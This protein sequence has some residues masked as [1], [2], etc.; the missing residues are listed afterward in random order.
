MAALI[1]K[2]TTG[3]NGLMEHRDQRTTNWFLLGSPWPNLLLVAT[4]IFISTKGGPWFM[5]NR[6]PYDIRKIMVA[7]NL[8]MV[9]LSSYMVYE[10]LF[11][12]WLDGYTL[13]C[14]LVDYSDAPQAVRMANVSWWFYFSK[15]IELLDTIFFILRKKFNLVTFLHV[16]H[17]A[18]MPCVE[19]AG[20]SFAPGGFGTFHA[21]LNCSVHVIM[22]TYYG[23][24]AMGP[25]MQKYLWWKR[26]MTTIQIVQLCGM[27]IHS[28]QI[29]F[30][31][32]QYSKVFGYTILIG[33]FSFVPL[34][35]NFYIQAYLSK[36]K[37]EK[38]ERLHQNGSVE[39]NGKIEH[40]N[41]TVKN[42]SVVTNGISGKKANGKI[43]GKK[44]NGKKHN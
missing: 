9:Y 41:G 29:I 25:H 2:I 42:G 18:L 21:L 39:Q 35:L 24:A 10:F 32:C 15:V 37:K 19:W 36:A 16:Y 33:A 40:Q 27:V 13:G 31:D 20:V 26:Y 4:Y 12:G 38:H 7:Y 34:F 22:Y 3:Y 28:S 14:Q 23:L 5:K 11:A 30:T 43:N 6:E 1:D 44:Q 17:H 8:F